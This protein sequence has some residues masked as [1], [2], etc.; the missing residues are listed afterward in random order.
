[1]TL[2]P[3]KIQ[4]AIIK[5]FYNL[6][7][8]SVKYYT[9][10]A[11]GKNN[12]CLF[13]EIRLLRA[14]IDILR[15]FK[16]VNNT[17]SCSCC[18]EGSYMIEL[19]EGVTI[20]N[21]P[22]QFNCNNKGYLIYNGTGYPFTYYY[23]NYNSL[24]KI[25]FDDFSSNIIYNDLTFTESCNIT[26]DNQTQ[27]LLEVAEI[28]VTGT[29]I[30][31]EGYDGS[32][33]ILDDSLNIIYTIGIPL[34]IITDPEAIVDLWNTTNGSS[35]FLLSYINGSY[36]FTSPLNG[37]DYS[38][39]VG[40]F[41]QV[42]GGLDPNPVIFEAP[43][44][45]LITSNTPAHTVQLIPTDQFFSGTF[46]NTGIIKMDPILTSPN[47]VT[48]FYLG[49]P[50]YTIQGPI[51][52]LTL[53][54]DFNANNTLGF[55]MVYFDVTSVTI[56]SPLKSNVYNTETI[57]FDDSVIVRFGT[58]SGGALPISGNIVLTDDTLG[59]I[60]T[61][62]ASNFN[63]V[64]DYINDFNDNNTGNLTAVYDGLQVTFTRVYYTAPPDTGW[65]YNETELSYIFDGDGYD[66]TSEWQF[67]VDT[68]AGS[69]AVALID[70]LSNTVLLYND[71]TIVNYS[72][73]E[74]FQTAFNNSLNNLG[75][76]LEIVEKD[77]IFSPPINTF[78]F[79]ND[80]QI[81][82]IYSYAS[83][84]YTLVQEYKEFENGVNPALV[85]YDGIFAPTGY[86][87]DFINDNPCTPKII[88]QT[89]LSNN[90][91]ENIINHINK[92]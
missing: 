68:T 79:Y 37:S 80:Y 69:F 41:N 14:Y 59:V 8:K 21:S 31:V 23:D 4:I 38:G 40:R 26:N 49:N 46:A 30:N 70:T 29:P 61:S 10:L 63:S 88:E 48:C 67:G 15:N 33:E 87:G 81:E 64:Q 62:D 92:M 57:S 75:F 50:I 82:L 27:S 45:T 77:F 53:I 66:Y 56:Q 43:I 42:E 3:L 24:I 51:D 91:V 35:G 25:T 74:E 78:E 76:S 19:V 58:F 54:D 17:I 65:A 52:L 34:A 83:S 73:Y 55:T 5:A 39:W 22:I 20:T 16:I 85:A 11:F 71:T 2:T 18:I 90:D 72:S 28:T 7:L 32:L 47:L 6:A 13:K 1:M 60:Y 12:I 84:E 9:G 89:C 36:V 44:P 86:L